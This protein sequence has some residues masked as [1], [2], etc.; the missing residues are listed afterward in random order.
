MILLRRY[1]YTTRLLATMMF[2]LLLAVWVSL[3]RA[4]LAQRQ[5][6]SQRSLSLMAAALPLRI[7]VYGTPTDQSALWLAN[8]ISWTDILVLGRSAPLSFLSKAEVRHWPVAGW[9][10]EQAGTLFIRRGNAV[11]DDV[12]GQLAQCLSSGH[13]LLIFPE[14]TTTDGRQTGTF[15]SRL[16]SCAVDTGRPIQPV[17]LRYRRDG[18]YDAIAP[19]VGDEELPS[20]LFRLFSHGPA[21][22]EVHFLPLIDTCGRSRTQV[23]REARQAIDAIVAT[24]AAPCSIAQPPELEAQ[25][26]KA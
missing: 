13:S 16:L 4:N 14:G 12:S 3:K 11:Q 25:E 17:A 20:H 7:R 22:V 6:L 5:R 9:L 2:P 21:E 8:H 15:H 23:A 24:E 18:A 26:A 10:A 1:F 19:F